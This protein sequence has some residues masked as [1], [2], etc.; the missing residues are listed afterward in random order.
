MAVSAARMKHRPRPGFISRACC[1]VSVPIVPAVSQRRARVRAAD[2]A[3]C[4]RLLAVLVVRAGE[5]RG[6][7]R[8]RVRDRAIQRLLGDVLSRYCGRQDSQPFEIEVQCV[9]RCE[10][11]VVR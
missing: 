3:W 9:A 11:A 5:R 7:R 8:A 1:R 4:R 6:A 10:A 2:S